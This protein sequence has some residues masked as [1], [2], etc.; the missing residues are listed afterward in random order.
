[1][2]GLLRSRV[3]RVFVAVIVVC[4]GSLT[5]GSRLAPLAEA[6]FGTVTT[7]RSQYNYG[8]NVNI[9]FQIT[10]PGYVKLTLEAPG[11]VDTVIYAQNVTASGDCVSAPAG[12][13]PSQRTV[14][15][16][17]SF[18]DGFPDFTASTTYTVS[19]SSGPSGSCGTTRG[20][21]CTA[22]W[23]DKSQYQLGE[24]LH[25]CYSVSVPGHVRI[26]DT[27]PDGSS[28]VVLDGNDD[29]SGDCRSGTITPP[30][31]TERLHL[32]LTATIYCIT[33]PCPS[34]DETADTSFQVISAPHPVPGGV[35]IGPQ[36]GYQTSGP[37]HLA[38]HAYTSNPGDPSIREVDFT[39]WWPGVGP[40]SG[41]WVN[42]CRLNTPSSGDVYECD[43]NLAAHNAPAGQVLI[44]FDVY[45]QAGNSNLSPNG[46]RTIIFSPPMGPTITPI[47]P[48]V[49]T[50][51]TRVP[52]DVPVPT[53]TPEPPNTP[54]PQPASVLSHRYVVFIPGICFSVHTWGFCPTHQ[55]G[56]IDSNWRAWDTFHSLIGQLDPWAHSNRVRYAYY[57]YWIHGD[58][59]PPNW[60]YQDDTHHFLND[61]SWQ[62]DSQ[63]RAIMTTN[64]D[65]HA[66]FDLVSHSLGGVVA[67][68][69]AAKFADPWM[70]A[71][72]HS[73]I[74]FD[75]PLQGNWG[76]LAGD[77]ALGLN[78]AL[79]QSIFTGNA[80]FDLAPYSPVVLAVRDGSNGTTAKLPGKVFTIGNS[81]D[82]VVNALE[83][84]LDRAQEN[85]QIHFP[86]GAC[87]D[88]LQESCHGTVLNDPQALNWAKSWIEAS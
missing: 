57:S 26:T 42:L 6:H 15:F 71:K 3:P 9:C 12:P 58:L 62:L 70:L 59:K 22:I 39:A 68:Y 88:D 8:D 7:D 47:V 74:S 67:A 36:S 63:L 43:V 56:R 84:W 54:T 35:W 10:D 46:E 41:P 61:S 33:T 66:T 20:Q 16:D 50:V 5:L 38:A 87:T 52:T 85:K 19:G 65:P 24:S 86:F 29:G 32:E 1:M 80:G 81:Q 53:Y 23:T 18:S 28:Q 44:S 76:G 73:M 21:R 60:Y 55:D 75:S 78:A 45:D 4:S 13:P 83:S 25:Y 69:W 49:P 82:A 79:I 51:I 30:T 72:I 34:V 77:L 64:K 31:G 14:L 37:L 40:Q 17:E 2:R 11:P 48:T 27:L